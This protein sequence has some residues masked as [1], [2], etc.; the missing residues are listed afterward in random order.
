MVHVLNRTVAGPPL[1][2]KQSDYEAFARIMIEAH[3][4][5]PTSQVGVPPP[6]TDA[7]SQNYSNRP[8]LF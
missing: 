7:A 5:Q 6:D 8:M 1:F 2:H 3:Q 4:R